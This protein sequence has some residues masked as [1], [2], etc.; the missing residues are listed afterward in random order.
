VKGVTSSIQTQLD[1]KQAAGTYVTS[2]TGTS[3]IVSSGGT[4]PAISIPVATTSVN[5][6]LSSTDWTTFNNKASTAALA[7]YLPLAGGTLTGAL[8]GT[9]AT[10]S[11]DLIAVS[12]TLNTPANAV[13][14]LLN[15]RTSDNV[16]Q[17]RFGAYTGGGAYNTI[18]ASPTSFDI[19]SQGNTPITFGTN[20]GGG[21]GTRVTITGAGAVTLTGALNGTS[22]SFSS[23]LSV[24][25]GAI[26]LT[27]TT[28][29]V[30][31]GA[32]TDANSLTIQ[33]ANSNYL[34]RFKNAAS[35]S[36]GGFYYDG[37]NFIADGPSW[38]F[39]YAATFS[40][41]VT[42]A[43]L[44]AT[45]TAAG[46][47]SILTNTNGASDSNG[48]LVKAGS[49][50]TEYVVRFAPQSDASTFFAVKGNG[51]VGIGTASPSFILDVQQAQVITRLLST[52]GTN[53]ASTRWSNTG[54]SLYVGIEQSATGALLTGDIAYAGVIARTGAYPLQFGTNDVLRM[55]I[56]SGGK[57]LIGTDTS[58]SG[59]LIISD[60]NNSGLTLRRGTTADRL[61]LFIGASSP[62]I[63]DDPYIQSNNADIHIRAGSTGGVKLSIGATSFV[64]DS[65]IRLKNKI[66]DIDN[67]LESILKLE[68]LKFNWK[69]D[70]ELENKKAYF[71]L[72]AQ[73]VQEILPELI[74]VGRDDMQ[75]LGVKYTEL[76]PVL[77][78]AIQEL[79][80]KLDKNNI[81]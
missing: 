19:N 75:T 46:Y 20:V 7:A 68:T 40:S 23:G 57:V 22:A 3:P 26:S 50:S 36:L 13:G 27:P 8:N 61:L 5:G 69:Y 44:N 76:I 1:G 33:S 73:N 25:S 2:V 12:A 21:G 60:N 56:T 52:T 41:S 53:S 58:G 38:K 11:G 70:S 66:S 32:A 78:K 81:N 48:L 64:S 67:A 9:T 62:Y 47:A 10:F 77:V 59:N 43:Q 45:T 80:E 71:G 72:N 74:D 17:I 28:F 16:S 34:L 65:D 35:V 6:Y 51:N 31:S 4:T 37:T 14:V 30:G 39:I 55:T 79:N 49:T 24:T 54:G 15:G 29:S 18:Q 63:V 42:A